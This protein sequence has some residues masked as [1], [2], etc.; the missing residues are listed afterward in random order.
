MRK[1][2]VDLDNCL[3][4]CNEADMM[5]VIEIGYGFSILWVLIGYNRKVFIVYNFVLVLNV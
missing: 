2:H 4:S 3:E 5:I 1:L